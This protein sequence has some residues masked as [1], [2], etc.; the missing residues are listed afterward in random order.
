MSKGGST[1]STELVRA[2]SALAAHVHRGRTAEDVLRIAGDGAAR[3]GLR[4]DAFQVA[5]SDLVLRSLATSPERAALERLL[6]RRLVGLRAPLARCGLASEVVAER[7]SIHRSDLDLFVRFVLA[8]TGKDPLCLDTSTATSGFSNGVAA[9]LVVR[10]EPW[11]LLTMTS[12][13]L[14][15][16]DAAA[17]A[18]FAAH[19]G[20]ALEVS[21]FVESLRRTQDE[22]VARERL[23]TIGELAA[24]V[25]HEIRNPL[26][27]LFNSV[28]ALRRLVHDEASLAR[29]A[30][31]VSLLS[32]VNEEAVRLEEI[33]TDLLELA[34]PWTMRAEQTSLASVVQSVTKAVPRLPHSAAVE[35]RV[36]HCA[37]MPLVEIDRRMVRQALLNL[38]VNA[39]QAMPTGGA[40][41]VETRIEHRDDASFACVDVSDTGT[42][43][44]PEEQDRVLEPFYTTKASGTGLGLPLVKR[45]VE[46]H[47]GELAVT[48]DETGTTFT[49]R[50]PLP[51]W[52]E[53]QVTLRRGA[54]APRPLRAAGTDR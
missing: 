26:G 25:A 19:V 23:A 38:V 15:A 44:A 52:D 22:L 1:V 2:L 27:V 53:S 36:I 47:R 8:A 37:E 50:L 40:L 43:I 9:P 51:K 34:R 45:V 10:G 49:I 21:D 16:E 46:A 4:L 14:R 42:G 39:I 31:T 32:I 33:V 29:R 6:G 18:L 28:S 35:V 48:S 13:S 20:S 12:P 17:V 11:G 5:G 30:D 54:G 24:T 7:R 41:L 3:L